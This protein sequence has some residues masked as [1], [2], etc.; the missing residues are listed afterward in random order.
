MQH[1]LGVF[2]TERLA[3]SKYT[4]KAV[5][6]GGLRGCSDRTSAISSASSDSKAFVGCKEEGAGERFRAPWLTMV[7]LGK[8]IRALAELNS[9]LTRALTQTSS[10]EL[11]ACVGSYEYI[12][13]EIQKQLHLQAIY[14][15]EI[16]DR[17][18]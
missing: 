2:D 12:A 4:E 13:A 7:G 6:L 15:M 9:D 3:A 5:E 8:T 16:A 17:A 11:P 1:Y 18:I 10:N 14:I